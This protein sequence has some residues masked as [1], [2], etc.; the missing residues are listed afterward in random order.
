MKVQHPHTGDVLASVIT[1]VMK[2]WNIPINKVGLLISEIGSNMIKVINLFVTEKEKTASSSTTQHD[3]T[4]EGANTDSDS[5]GFE[6]EES[7]CDESGPSIR[8]TMGGERNGQ[9][10]SHES[11]GER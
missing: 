4:I 3:S 10:E 11:Q 7:D 6:T 9:C 8:P 5:D 1:T 2:I